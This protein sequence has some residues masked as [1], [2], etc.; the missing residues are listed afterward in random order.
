MALTITEDER[1]LIMPIT[2]PAFVSLALTNDFFSWQKEYDQFKREAKAAYMVNAIW[3]LTQE[4][5]IEI[6]KAKQILK[7]KIASYCQEYLRLKAE[8]QSSKVIS[9]DV[10]NYLSALEL[11]IAGNVGWSQFTPRYN[12]AGNFATGSPKKAV[13]GLQNGLHQRK[14]GANGHY[15]ADD[16]HLN[17][18]GQSQTRLLSP[19]SS[20]VCGKC[21]DHMMACQEDQVQEASPFPPSKVDPG[22]RDMVSNTL[23]EVDRR[24]DRVV[25]TCRSLPMLSDEVCY[26]VFG[27]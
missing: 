6:E 3:I 7:D 10:R 8:F 16:S 12:F 19:P 4:H 15:S 2:A 24:E 22:K 17:E 27:A 1:K 11:S 25:L 9:S 21:K 23:S 13:D 26:P 5:S 20:V 18:D 14:N